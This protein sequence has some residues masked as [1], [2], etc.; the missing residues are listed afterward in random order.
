MGHTHTLTVRKTLFFSFDKNCVFWHVIL[1]FV[2]LVEEGEKHKNLVTNKGH[3]CGFLKSCKKE[4]ENKKDL[5]FFFKMTLRV[6]I[7]GA[8]NFLQKKKHQW[9][10]IKNL[11]TNKGHNCGFPKSCKKE[12]ENTK[13]FFF[14]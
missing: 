9:G 10:G 11:V 5:L 8:P 1:C 6:S 2:R 14:K 7:F 13:D 4:E 12:E 3:N